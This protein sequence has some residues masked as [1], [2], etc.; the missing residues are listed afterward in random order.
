MTFRSSKWFALS[1][2]AWVLASA[3][4][5]PA[6]A[7]QDLNAVLAKLD[8]GAAKFKS[9]QADVVWENVQTQPIYDSDKQAGTILFARAGGQVEVAL[10]L[11]TDNGKPIV[12]DMI[13][14]DGKGK[15]YDGQLKQLQVFEVGDKK[16]SLDAFLTLG[17]GGSGADLEK[18]WTVTYEGAEA[19]NGAQAAKLQL[20]PKDAAV[21][22][23]SPKVILWVDMDKG[24]GL[25]QQ[26]FDASGNYAVITYSNIKLGVPVGSG[27]FQMKTPSGT[28]V[29]NH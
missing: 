16:S 24:V 25:K 12:K 17:F 13:Y 11:K 2:M 19:V 22:K 21:A 3:A 4:M 5:V 23:T 27:A 20:V 15:L 28:Q 18:A 10:H 26:R 29:V 14:A 1:V 8:A 7:A 9:A 6:A